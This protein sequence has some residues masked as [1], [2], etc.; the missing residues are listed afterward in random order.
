MLA[1]LRAK[2]RRDAP[3]GVEWRRQSA[4]GCKQKAADYTLER[5]RLPWHR[6][7]CSG[8]LSELTSPVLIYVSFPLHV[9]QN[10]NS[11]DIHIENVIEILLPN[12][13]SNLYFIMILF[14]PRMFIATNK[15]FLLFPTLESLIFSS[16]VNFFTFLIFNYK[17]KFTLVITGNM[18]LFFPAFSPSANS[19]HG[20]FSFCLKSVDSLVLHTR[21][22]YQAYCLDC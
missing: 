9:F 16:V 20:I 12:T 5:S 15:R 17:I 22:S 19:Y 8:T 14:L 18:G 6:R 21:H 1:C 2:G 4:V 7:C 13:Q 10:V 11:W 3:R